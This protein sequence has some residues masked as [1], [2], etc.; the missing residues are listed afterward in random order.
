MRKTIR[1]PPTTL[2][3]VLFDFDQTMI[4][5]EPQHTVASAALCRVMGSDYE[6]LPEWIRFES[7]RRILDEIAEM[8]AIFGWTASL[9]ELLAERQVFFRTACESSSLALLPCVEKVVRALQRQG[10]ILAVTSSAVG[11][12]IEAIL[13]RFGLREAFAAI[14]DGSMVTHAKPD[15]EAYL[16]T[17][18][19]LGVSPDECL[20][21]EDSRVGV[22]AAK[23]AGMYC[24]AVRAAHARLAQD[25]SAADLVLSTFSELQFDAHGRLAWPTTDS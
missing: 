3:A 10:L 22:L 2:R 9:D 1:R 6:Q 5:L 21:F 8:R 14:V 12:E 23:A 16:V 11:P 20:V 17:A 18:E 4:D 7:G 15:P 25:V 13:R 19:V 24:V